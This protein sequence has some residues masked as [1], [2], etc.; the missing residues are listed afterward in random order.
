MTDG[1]P[2]LLAG[3]DQTGVRELGALLRSLFVHRHCKLVQQVPLQSNNCQVFRLRFE[4]AGDSFS[5]V[6]KKHKPNIAQ[7]NEAVIQRWLPAL[8]LGGASPRLLGVAAECAGKCVWHVYE[9]LGPWA[10]DPHAPSREKISAAIE[11]IARL[12]TA[13]VGH[14][15]LAEARL[16]GGDLGFNF[17]SASVRDAIRCLQSLC[18]PVVELSADHARVRDGL[19]ERMRDLLEE[20]SSRAQV[21]AEHGGPETLLHGD[22]WTCNAFVRPVA[23]SYRAWLIDWDHAAVGPIS[24]DLSTFLLRFS[25]QW[26]PWILGRYRAAVARAGWNL[27]AAKPLNQLFETAELSRLANSII[28][29]ALAL[30][31]APNGWGW[32]RLADIQQWL[33]Q[34]Q[35]VL[36]LDQAGPAIIE[37]IL[38]ADLSQTQCGA[39]KDR[40]TKGV[41]CP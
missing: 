18:P 19:L 12:H 38:L 27:P 36:P 20:L 17:F 8:G 37:G 5:L 35:P 4:T 13:F 24:Y 39:A 22:L 32:E 3:T 34:M 15:L 1:L 30:V 33:G 25:R 14:R 11:L 10:L 31:R 23:G 7:R 6:V 26:R 2:S 16:E 29:P 41:E 28:W 9:D 40:L 21:F